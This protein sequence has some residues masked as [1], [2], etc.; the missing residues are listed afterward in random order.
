MHA[1]S[2]LAAAHADHAQVVLPP[3]PASAVHLI[4]SAL[5]P[6]WRLLCRGVSRAWRAALSDPALWQ[7]LEASAREDFPALRAAAAL[8]CG[9]L[10]TLSVCGYALTNIQGYEL[11]LERMVLPIVRENASSLRTLR[12]LPVDDDV[13]LRVSHAR[14]LLAAAPLLE[15]LHMDLLFDLD[16]VAELR[17]VLCG[18]PPF[19]P[20][21]LRTLDCVTTTD[22]VSAAAFAAD[23]E[24]Q[25]SGDGAH[26]G[27]PEADP[28]APQSLRHA[29]P[30]AFLPL[31]ARLI[32]GG[33]EYLQVFP[34]ENGNVDLFSDGADV[35]DF[36]GACRA[37]TTL[38]KLVLYASRSLEAQSDVHGAHC[39]ALLAALTG[40]PTLH[41]LDLSY[42]QVHPAA[43]A[44]VGAALGTLI[45]ANESSL[46][47]LNFRGCAL[48]NAGLL[49]VADA[50]PRNM[51]LQALKLSGNVPT[52]DF[53]TGTLARG[54]CAN[55]SLV[56]LHAGNLPEEEMHLCADA[57]TDDA[58]VSL[59][60]IVEARRGRAAGL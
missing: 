22:A 43:A 58:L 53:A 41:Q 30:R 27:A 5:P 31:L 11:L 14:Q 40:H 55:T 25:A 2:R 49:A 46:R 56:Y 60:R 51:H 54:V 24:L 18:R 4:F 29:T 35:E 1:Q 36:A 15:T 19:G 13:C 17:A 42:Y 38:Q 47:E 50:L 8:A 39:A 57:E 34:E 33:L 45:A 52:A 21:K 26:D 10:R 59:E 9:G 32:R 23:A 7:H 16:E 20:L 48:G 6:R 44:H 28:R 37:S 3:L 12:L